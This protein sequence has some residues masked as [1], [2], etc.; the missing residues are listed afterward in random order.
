LLSRSAE[1]RR[2][3]D[4]DREIKLANMTDEEREEF[5]TRVE[6]AFDD[7]FGDNDT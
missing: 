5:L 2:I 6:E 3:V 1:M 4:Q 7:I